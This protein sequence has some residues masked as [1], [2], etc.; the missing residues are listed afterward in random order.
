MMV[1][2]MQFRINTLASLQAHFIFI[3][4]RW[5]GTNYTQRWRGMDEITPGFIE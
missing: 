3:S 2:M 4:T 5:I 1:V